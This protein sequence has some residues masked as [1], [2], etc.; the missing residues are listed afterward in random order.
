MREDSRNY[1]IVG[2]FVLAMLVALITWI[3]LLSG[4]TGA[5]DDYHIVYDNVM[6]LKTGVEILYEGYPVGL[7]EDISPVEQDGRDSALA[8]QPHTVGHLWACRR[9]ISSGVIVYR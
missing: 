6:G 5:T 7:I 1:M 4:R 8:L 2:S 9:G 3:A